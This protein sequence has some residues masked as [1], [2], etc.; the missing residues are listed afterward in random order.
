VDTLEAKI[1]HLYFVQAMPRDDDPLL[2]RAI[3]ALSG[4]AGSAERVGRPFLLDGRGAPHLAFNAFFAGLRM[5]NRAA[6]TNRKYAFA[7]RVWLNFLELRGVSWDAARDDDLFDY[8][9][10]RR[11]DE[12]NPRR[13][14]GSTWRDD[15]SAISAFNDWA[16]RQHGVRTPVGTSENFVRGGTVGTKAWGPRLDFSGSRGRAGASRVRSADVK[17][18]SPGAYRRWRDVG[19]LG[20]APDGK[21]R[22]RWRPRSQTR[23]AAFVDGLYGTG[24]RIQEWSSVLVNE[25]RQ[26]HGDN[27]YVTLQLADAT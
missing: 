21:E 22:T 8:K 10:W 25:L 17:W 6:S 5:R 13:V 12:A 24:L 26:P 9:F 27:N 16:E 23:D 7:L 14:A 3:D 18:F 19:I 1:W 11:T 2:A 15:L 20:I 4:V